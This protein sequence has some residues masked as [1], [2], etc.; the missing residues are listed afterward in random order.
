MRFYLDRVLV[1]PLVGDMS[2]G[3]NLLL[4]GVLAVPVHWLEVRRVISNT[5]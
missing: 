4:V 5:Q 1:D 3:H 2:L